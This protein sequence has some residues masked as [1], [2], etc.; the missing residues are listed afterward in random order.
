MLVWVII[1]III[2]KI[3][4]LNIP[5]N[6][7]DKKLPSMINHYIIKKPFYS[8]PNNATKPMKLVHSDVIGKQETFFNDFN[9]Y[10]TFLYDF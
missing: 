5:K 10:V 2:L 8:S 6:Q 9:Y 1:I 7:N 4:L 3:L